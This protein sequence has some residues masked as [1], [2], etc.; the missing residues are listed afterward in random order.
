[1]S[2]Q[3]PVTACIA[4]IGAVLVAAPASAASPEFEKEHELGY[5]LYAEERYEEAIAAFERAYAIEPEPLALYNIARC[6]HLWERPAEAIATYERFLAAAPEHEL[7]DKTKRYMEEA[8]LAVEAGAEVDTDGTPRDPF[9]GDPEVPED[10]GPGDAAPEEPAPAGPAAGPGVDLSP[11]A[12]PDTPAA[13]KVPA[14]KSGRRSNVLVMGLAIAG[15]GVGAVALVT[16]I[17]VAARPHASSR[18]AN[19]IDLRDMTP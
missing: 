10:P 13:T 9:S 3:G 4:I 16:V 18:Y 2:A 12:L 7:A 1:M 11:E 8:K 15:A 19:H 14:G 5:D 6:Y 17:A